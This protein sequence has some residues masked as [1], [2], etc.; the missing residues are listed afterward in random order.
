MS[1]KVIAVNKVWINDNGKASE[2]AFK[3]CF[4]LV[5]SVKH[6]TNKHL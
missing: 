6:Q 1:E 2:P 5:I 4:V 3:M